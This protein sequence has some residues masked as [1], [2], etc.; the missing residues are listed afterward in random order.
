MARAASGCSGI[1]ACGCSARTT[2]RH[3]AISLKEPELISAQYRELN[4]LLHES[5]PDYGTSAYKW[6]ARVADLCERSKAKTVLDY[7]CGKR[8][9]EQ[10]LREHYSDAP[11]IEVF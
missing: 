5:R 8:L 10:G 3:G 1:R 7:G 2:K 11:V 6:A 9:L 4:R